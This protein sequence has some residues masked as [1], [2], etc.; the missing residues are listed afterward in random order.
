MTKDIETKCLHL[1]EEEERNNFH[2][3]FGSV[4]FPIFQTAAYVHPGIRDDYVPG[5]DHISLSAGYNYSRESNP[6]RTQLEKFVAQLEGGAGALAFSS[7]M[8][9]I[10]AALLCVCSSGDEIIAGNIRF[11]PEW[12]SEGIEEKKSTFLMREKEN[13]NDSKV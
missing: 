2:S 13:Y 9:A 10:T 5:Q 11:I 4:S 6:T 8:A 1:T 7:G 12:R 3:T